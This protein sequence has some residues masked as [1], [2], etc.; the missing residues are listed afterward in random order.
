MFSRVD[1]SLVAMNAKIY[2][3]QAVFRLILQYNGRLPSCIFKVKIAAAACGVFG[4]EWVTEIIFLEASKTLILIF[5]KQGIK[6]FAN[7]NRPSQGPIPS[8]I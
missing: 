3:S 6:R 4:Q 8:Q 5:Q 2:L 1:T 7:H